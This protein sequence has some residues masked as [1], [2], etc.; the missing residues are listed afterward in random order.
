V[1]SFIDTLFVSDKGGMELRLSLD[2][3]VETNSW[4]QDSA[5]AAFETLQEDIRT[6]RPMS[7]IL[8][9]I[10]KKLITILDNIG[11]LAKD[12][13]VSCALVALGIL[14]ILSPRTIEALGFVGGGILEGKKRTIP[15]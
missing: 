3:I 8:Q 4:K 7:N 11:G 5:Q 14:V 12:Y 2:K 6:A 13:Q 10:H 9:E 15:Q 1:N